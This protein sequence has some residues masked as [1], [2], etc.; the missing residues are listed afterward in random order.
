MQKRI[1]CSI[2]AVALVSLSGLAYAQL[3]F[4]TDYTTSDT[5][6]VVVNVKVDS[7][8]IDF[9]LEGIKQTWVTGNEVAKELGQVEDYAIYISEFQDSG[10]FNL[11]LVTQFADLAQY[12]KGRKEF[13]QFEERWLERLPEEQRREV[14]ANYPSMRTI[15]GEYLMRE[16]TLQ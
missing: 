1:L 5:V 12:D 9:Y 15:V 11:T 3:R 14:V 7:N 2:L 6:Y 13:A 8:M 16:V 10:N 4:G